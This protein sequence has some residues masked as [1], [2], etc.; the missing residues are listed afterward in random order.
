MTSF[1]EDLSVAKAIASAVAEKGGRVYFVGG[2]VRD[3]LLGRNTKDI[4]LEVHGLSP[5]QLE[6]ILDF[7]GERLAIGESFG[8]Y[9]LKGTGLDI[10][11]PRK[12]TNR[13]HGHRDFS[14]FVDPFLGEKEAARRRDFTVN[15]LME[16]VLTGEI[17]DF[18]GG[19][20]DLSQKIL[21]HVDEKTFPE[22]PLRVL[23]AA[24]FAARF[25][26]SVDEAT[27]SLGRGVDLRSLPKERV[28]AELKKALLGSP[29]PSVFFETLRK[30]DQLSVWFPELSALIGVPQNPVFHAEGDV[31]NHTMLVLNAAVSYKDAVLDP[32]DFLLSALTH[33]LGKAVTTEEINGVLHA[34]EHKTK[35][36]PLVH[37][38]LSRLTDEKALFR[39]VLP[40]VEHHMKPNILAATGASVK[41][42]NHLFDS[43]PD[44][45]ALAAL[46]L[47]D[48][49][50]KIPAD[51]NRNETFFAERIAAYRETMARPFVTGEDLLKAGLS[52]SENF[53]ELLSYAH[54]LRLARVPKDAALKQV[55][56]LAR[57][58]K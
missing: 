31:W 14:V 48:G 26:F 8:I 55:L 46:A 29:K 49:L 38:F 11:L 2:F 1:E 21:R 30:M 24:Q 54:K 28:F 47:C 10:A 22:D 33:D 6:P 42:T 51:E 50:G 4:D 34:Y 7:F 44:P 40:L 18:F 37:A 15:A 57:K 39:Y 32:L 53:S 41:S 52:P 12:E 43:V 58:Q 25:G 36:L 19:R 56:A 3:Q 13:G 17:L 16:D 35:G 5:D 23:R 27:L 20:N 9:T 45:E